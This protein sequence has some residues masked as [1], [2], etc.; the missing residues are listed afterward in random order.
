M[1]RG[2]KMK[3]GFLVLMLLSVAAFAAD[4]CVLMEFF[5]SNG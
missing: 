2:M 1:K 5:T 3:T 4:R